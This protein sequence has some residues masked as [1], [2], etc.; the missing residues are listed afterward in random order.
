MK[1]SKLNLKKVNVVQLTN[2]SRIMGGIVLPDS[3]PIPTD[4]CNTRAVPTEDDDIGGL[5]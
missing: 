4:T 5:I 1:K 3:F 2:P